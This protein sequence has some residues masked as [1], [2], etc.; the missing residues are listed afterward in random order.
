MFLTR[1]ESYGIV[2]VGDEEEGELLEG[3]GESFTPQRHP[4]LHL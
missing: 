3:G 2:G 4:H 1:A